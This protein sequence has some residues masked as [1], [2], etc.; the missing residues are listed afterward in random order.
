MKASLYKLST[1]HNKQTQT[2]DPQKKMRA[3]FAE[4][5]TMLRSLHGTS[6]RMAGLIYD[7][8]GEE[9]AYF[10]PEELRDFLLSSLPKF[11]SH[12]KY[13]KPKSNIQCICI[14]E[15]EEASGASPDASG[16]GLVMVSVFS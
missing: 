13:V 8:N 14:D 11:K 16:V 3:L 4:I 9:A 10:G 7:E 1:F 2:M 6:I 5:D 12:S 15:R